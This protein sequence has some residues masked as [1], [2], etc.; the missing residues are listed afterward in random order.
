MTRRVPFTPF[1]VA[2]ALL[3]AAGA[4]FAQTSCE[5]A[6]AQ[7]QKSYDLGAFD[8][9]PAQLAPCLDAKVRR[10]VAV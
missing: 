4:A 2:A 6:L 5:D 8:D 9:V 3:L 10:R 7:A 1:V